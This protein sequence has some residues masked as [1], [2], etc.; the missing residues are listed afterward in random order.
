MRIGARRTSRQEEYR[1]ICDP[2]SVTDRG[3]RACEPIDEHEEHGTGRAEPHPDRERTH[4]DRGTDKPEGIRE[5]GGDQ[6]HSQAGAPEQN[7]SDDRQELC[8]LRGPR[9]RGEERNK[10][11]GPGL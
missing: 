7:T 9:A 4:R 1:R 5:V 2:L 6:R 8:S 10:G 11:P 3:D